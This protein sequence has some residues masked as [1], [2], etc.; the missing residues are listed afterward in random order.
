M[1]KSKMNNI[2][3]RLMQLNDREFKADPE[4]MVALLGRMQVDREGQV[5]DDEL[6]QKKN[7]MMRSL[8]QEMEDIQKMNAI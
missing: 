5:A 4:Q 7:E 3:D 8:E 1:L 2:N 6:C